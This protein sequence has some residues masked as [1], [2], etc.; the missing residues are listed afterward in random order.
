MSTLDVLIKEANKSVKHDVLKV[1]ITREDPERISTGVFQL[2]VA[3][4]G[5]FPVG[6]ISLLYGTEAS[7]KTTLCLK[8][9]AEAQKKWPEKRSV[10]FDLEGHLSRSWAEKMGVDNERL[11]Y[12]TPANAEQFVDIIEHIVYATDV[13][14]IVVDSLAALVTTHELESDAEKAMVGTQ[15]IIINKFY[16]KL[17]RA[18]GDIAEAG[19]SP[20]ILL[21]NQIRF[22]VGV[23]MGDPEIMPGGPSFRYAS[24]I[25]LRLY[26]KDEMDKSLSETLPSFKKISAIVKKW[27]VPIAARN[28]EF[29]IALLPNPSLKLHV[30]QANDIAT[31]MY[32]LK[33]L[34]MLVKAGKEWNVISPHGEILLSCKLQEDVVAALVENESFLQAAKDGII[35]LMVT[36]GELLA[37][38]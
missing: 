34:N 14:V 37:A 19:Y 29:H 38:P 24:S 21:I 31:I 17:T 12:A 2:D 22:R 33:A 4:G 9:I 6:R 11:V 5:G 3:L 32:Y 25:T 1:G 27:K 13:A 30:G 28:S 18:M 15:G 10:F 23:M 7:M 20:T 8:V 16:R 26:G 35:H 36:Q